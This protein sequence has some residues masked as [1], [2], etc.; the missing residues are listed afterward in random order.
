MKKNHSPKSF[1]KKLLWAMALSAQGVVL[2]LWGQELGPNQHWIEQV[3]G[4]F[5]FPASSAI[6][7]GYG[8]GWGGDILIGYRFNRQFSLSGAVGHY[9]CDQKLAGADAGE[10]LYDNFMA[11]GRFNF[12]SGWVRP[13]VTLGA[14]LALNTYSLTVEPSGNK[15]EDKT[16]DF[17]LS[18]GA[19]VLFVVAGDMAL[20]VQSRLDM[21]FTPVGGAG[22][23]FVDSPTIFVPVKAGLSFFA[24]Q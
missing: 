1:L 16:V 19:G 24:A 9:D 2:P 22:S 7:Q 8:T 17:L 5:L 3:D 12:G 14:G 15:V 10:W 21:D 13:F 18:P 11:V 20:Y 4:G 6:A 23:P